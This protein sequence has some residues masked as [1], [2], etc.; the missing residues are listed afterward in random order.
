MNEKVNIKSLILGAFIT[1]LIGLFVTAIWQEASKKVTQKS[2]ASSAIAVTF[3]YAEFGVPMEETL[4]SLGI[5]QPNLKNGDFK[6]LFIISGQQSFAPRYGV[7][8]IKN[9]TTRP[10]ELLRVNFG[11]DAVIASRQSSSNFGSLKVLDQATSRQY[12]VGTLAPS[13]ELSF[14]VW[15][16]A[17]DS[18]RSGD[19][20]DTHNKIAVRNNDF[21]VNPSSAMVSNIREKYTPVS[22]YIFGRT[23]TLAF[24]ILGAIFSAIMLI[25][26]LIVAF[27]AIFPKLTEKI[28]EEIEIEKLLSDKHRA[29]IRAE[30]ISK[31]KK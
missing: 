7:L 10:I 21:S 15:F 16:D 9:T 24:A 6:N 20:E 18:S 19:Y 11:F 2:P 28:A 13:D 5:K 31:R 30:L 4:L 29:D 3:D 8:T 26:L 14:G 17:F 12:E 1:T 25:M 23:L 22:E 27:M